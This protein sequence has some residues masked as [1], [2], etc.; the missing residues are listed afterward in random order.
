LISS[1]DPAHGRG[2]LPLTIDVEVPTPLKR[3]R[4]DY[5]ILTLI[6]CALSATAFIYYWHSGELLLYGDAVAHMNIAR[7]VVD[8]RT[9]GLLQLGTV[10]LPLPHLLMLPFIW[11]TW[12]WQTG[13]GGAIPSMLAY[14]AGVV[15]IFRL[16]R[17]GM[18]FLPDFKTEARVSAWFAALVYALN[19]N[20]LYLQATAMTETIYL[21]CFIWATV[22][23][24]EFARQL[25]RGEDREGQR[26]VAYC[27]VALVLAMMTR[28]DGWFMAGTYSVVIVGLLIRA[29]L[30]SGLEPLSFLYDRS[31]RRAIVGLFLFLALLPCVWLAYNKHEFKDPLAFA[32]GP[33]SAK[34]IEAR[35]HNPGG[36][37]HPGWNSPT[38]S[39]TYFV[40]SAKLNMAAT[41]R[42]QRIWL[43]VALL[44]SVIVIGFIRPL[45]TWL[46]LWIPV[47]FYA[48]SMAWGG[49]PIFIPIWWPF[50]YYNVRYGTQLIPVFAVFGA[51]L[52]YLFLRRFAWLEMKRFV[53]AVAILFV[54]SSYFGVWREVPIC[55]REARVNSV[56]RIAIEAKLAAQ[57]AQLPAGSTVLVYLGEHGGALQSIGFP[58]KRTV[59]ECHKRYWRSALLSPA[60]M[61]DFVVATQG[62]PLSRAVIKHPQ[63][64]VRIAELTVRRQNPITIYRSTASR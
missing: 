29:S 9:P 30:R 17:N 60:M 4:R 1:A 35:T 33:Y 62:D 55:L 18:L 52:L 48:I 63:N 58:L 11:S 56:D 31:W 32:R 28:Y 36:W 12:M 46:L 41:D 21:A 50:S 8:S 49:V 14:V 54:A 19:P 34:G 7:R 3:G 20:L 44:A 22:F 43:Y 37:Q 47:P 15:G 40:E 16:V 59:N 2:Q 45:W 23:L 39:A 5:L 13:V 51:L 57:L 10:W 25:L 64:L 42:S 53:A 27:G 61:A 6:A 24:S 26:S 38:V